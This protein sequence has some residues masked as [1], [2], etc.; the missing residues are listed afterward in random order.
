MFVVSGQRGKSSVVD[1]VHLD[2][3]SLG[4]LDQL[5][6][7]TIVARVSNIEAAHTLRLRAQSSDDGMESE[8]MARVGHEWIMRGAGASRRRCLARSAS[9][10]RMRPSV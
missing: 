6:H 9:G 2:S 3:G 1:G 8:E 4:A 10:M 7:A 5:A